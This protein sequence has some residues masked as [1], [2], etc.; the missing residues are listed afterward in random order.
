M[1]CPSCKN[2]PYCEN[3]EDCKDALCY[4]YCPD[5]DD[6]DYSTAVYREIREQNGEF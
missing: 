6:E 5:Y 4:G 3:K 2:C 1:I